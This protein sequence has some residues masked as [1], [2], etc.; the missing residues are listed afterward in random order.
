MK[1]IIFNLLED[2]VIHDHGQDTWDELLN[3]TSLDGAYTSLGSYP[4]AHIQ[5]LVGAAARG[6]AAATHDAAGGRG[7]REDL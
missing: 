5:A 4:D 6:G 2:V 3:A 7:R 1:G